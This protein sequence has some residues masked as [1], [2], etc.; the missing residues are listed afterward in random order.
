MG[1]PAL[2]GEAKASTADDLRE[3]WS[4][5]SISLYNECARKFELS[6]VERLTP[7]IH[8]R[9]LSFGAAFHAGLSVWYR[10]QGKPEEEVREYI[11]RIL[12]GFNLDPDAINNLIASSDLHKMRENFAVII[13]GGHLPPLS[14]GQAGDKRSDEMLESLLRAYTKKYKYEPFRV[15]YVEQDVT[16]DLG[17]GKLYRTILDLI[18]EK[19]IADNEQGVVEHKTTGW[20]LKDF[21]DKFAAPNGQLA[22]EI[23]GTKTAVQTAGNDGYINGVLINSRKDGTVNIATDLMRFPCSRTD[24]QLSE[25]VENTLRTIESINTDLKRGY[26]NKNDNACNAYGG[27]QFKGIC[28]ARNADERALFTETRFERQP[29]DP[30]AWK[31]DRG[32]LI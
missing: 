31:R 32:H 8:G 5:H 22:G 10:T 27:C 21:G 28:G 7:K 9:A 12:T 20:T 25:F 18:I 3:V 1:D 4:N 29:Y 6:V 14:D 26:F 16:F 11:H 30:D 23:L 19:T 2:T 17:S 13:A 24:F 15:L